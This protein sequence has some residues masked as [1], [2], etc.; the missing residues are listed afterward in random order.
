[1][2]NKPLHII[3][4][5]N[6]FPPDYGGVIDVFYKLQR[7]HALGFDI[8][9]HCF[10][11]E[12]NI[13][14]DALKAITKA[15]YLYKKNRNPWFF[16]S[17]IPFGIESRF[18]KSLVQNIVAVEA[19]ILFEGLQTTMLL[20]KMSSNSKKYLRLHNL[21]SNFYTGMYR[22]ETNWIKKIMYYFEIG[23]YKQ[24]EKQLH[25]FDHVFTL[26]VYENSIVS[27]WTDKVTYVP[28]FHGNE[29]V[30]TL[31][32]QG[33]YA[34]YHG[35]LRLPDNKKAVS[36]LIE[37]FQGIPDYTLLIASSNGKDFV[38]SLIQK[39]ENIQFVTIT[40]EPHLD[41]LLENAHINVLLSFQ[42]SGTKLKLINSLF[43]SRFCLINENMVDDENIL[44]LCETASTAD[45]FI[46][47]IKELA[48]KPYTENERRGALLSEVLNDKENAEKIASLI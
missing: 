39:A 45:G 16:F 3:S 46:S 24:Y 42:K 36:F 23:K 20:H 33:D 4:F 2:Q 18:H 10:Y 32:A 37:L 28:V 48:T 30:K 40:S 27:A 25:H 11:D 1:M 14:S 22:S 5:D 29:K 44:Q 9:L 17:S 13:V 6:P 12:R 47:K 38:E 41:S 8:Y 26:S 15:V 35:D 7:L 43:K 19:P 34:L 31:S 21:E